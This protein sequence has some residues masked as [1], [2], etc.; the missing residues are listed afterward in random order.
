MSTDTEPRWYHHSIDRDH[1]G[2][3]HR[4]VWLYGPDGV[5]AHAEWRLFVKKGHGFGFQA[6][7]NGGESDIGL[8]V[9][10]GPIGSLWL[11]LRSPWTK[12]ANLSQDDG[13][14]WY[15]ARNYGLMFLPYGGCIVRW[16]FG[17]LEGH[18]SRN[19]PKWRD[20]NLTMTDVLGRRPCT[21]EEVEI[22]VAKVPMPEGNYDAT[23]AKE[24][25][26]WRYER[27]PGKLLDI[28]RGPKVNTS[29][30]L[31]IADGIPFQGKG[32]NSWD[33]GMDG[34]F[35]CGGSTVEAAVGRAVESVLRSRER[36]GGPHNLTEPTPVRAFGDS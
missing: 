9:Y 36:Y 35:G 16:E 19:F 12:W 17:A 28:I 14:Y 25:R 3:R 34:L 24:K 8:N 5:E 2:W 27:W 18:S 22:G 31:D 1:T 7:R 6:G 4:G 20:W 33:C 26:T 11:R 15:V 23:W 21:T 30:R 13:E 29:V 10:A 32:E